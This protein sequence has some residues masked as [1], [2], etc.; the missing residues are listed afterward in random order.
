MQILGVMRLSSFSLITAAMTGGAFAIPAAPTDLVF[1]AS[2]A[3]NVA[4]IR[5][6][7]QSDDEDAFEFEI[8]INGQTPFLNVQPGEDREIFTFSGFE[9][10]VPV[11]LRVRAVTLNDVGVVVERSAFSLSLI[12]I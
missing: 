7:D 8:S 6:V 4:T 2:E 9:P 11:S 10:G 5:W 1:L 3:D 12:H